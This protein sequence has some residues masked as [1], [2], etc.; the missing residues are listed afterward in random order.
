MSEDEPRSELDVLLEQLEEQERD[1]STRR[2]KLHDRMALFPDPQ[3][4]ADQKAQEAELSR[5]RHELHRRIDEV[6]AQRNAL[7]GDAPDPVE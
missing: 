6:R 7:R 4:E 2:R 5:Q 3:R 1:L